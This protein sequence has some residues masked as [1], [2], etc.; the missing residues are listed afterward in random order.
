MSQLY[1]KWCRGDFEQRQRIVESPDLFLRVV[2]PGDT[3]PLDVV[4]PL[5]ED[6]RIVASVS[7]RA[8]R[9]LDDGLISGVGE[10]SARR[11]ARHFHA[12]KES[13]ETL[14]DHFAREQRDVG[15]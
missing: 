12:A 2:A 15:A 10:A 9:R 7:A 1:D 13:F 4:K 3:P 5:V 8:T 11:M 14:A 6:L